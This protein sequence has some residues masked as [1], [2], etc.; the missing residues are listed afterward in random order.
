M[1]VMLNSAHYHKV[2][3]K[4]HPYNLCKNELAYAVKPKFNKLFVS[5]DS[6]GQNVELAVL[7]NS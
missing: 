7:Q 1:T 3:I 2:G 4:I 6:Y 5:C